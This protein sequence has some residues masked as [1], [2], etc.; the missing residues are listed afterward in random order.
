MQVEQFDEQG[1]QEENSEVIGKTTT[2]MFVKAKIGQGIG[3]VGISLLFV[4]ATITSIVV[5]DIV[6]LWMGIGMYS[7]MFLF[8]LIGI[9]IMMMGN[10]LGTGSIFQ[11]PNEKIRELLNPQG[12]LA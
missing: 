2:Q 12:G 6:A 10:Y 11:R 4:G 8:G 7:S 5:F 9:I 1:I 3:N